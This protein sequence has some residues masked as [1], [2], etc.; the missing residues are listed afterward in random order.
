MKT[1]KMPELAKIQHA[2][3]TKWKVLGAA[4]FRL[5]PLFSAVKAK[6]YVLT[7]TNVYFIGRYC[8][9]RYSTQPIVL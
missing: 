2:H 9:G 4:N 7:C 1:T 8:A 5:F 6:T 3:I